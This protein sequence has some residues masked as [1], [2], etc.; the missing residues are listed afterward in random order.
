MS[1]PWADQRGYVQH[2]H[3]IQPLHTQGLKAQARATGSQTQ[4]GGR[5]ESWQGTLL[6]PASGCG[7]QYLGRMH[8]KPH[9]WTA[10]PVNTA[11]ASPVAL[12]RHTQG[13]HT[14]TAISLNSLRLATISVPSTAAAMFF[15]A[16]GPQPSLAPEP[17]PRPVTLTSVNTLKHSPPEGDQ[18]TPRCV[19]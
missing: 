5:Q 7:E 18:H 16:L 8:P 17:E 9:L 3:E 15:R 10:T 12:Q 2:G 13:A 4:G 6:G 1:V 19:T 11:T 14:H